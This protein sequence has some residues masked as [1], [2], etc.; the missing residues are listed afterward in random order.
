MNKTLYVTNTKITVAEVYQKIYT[1]VGF[2]LFVFC[3][4]EV[5]KVSFKVG[6]H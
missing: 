6:D 5:L 1:Y 3:P 2:I 4:L